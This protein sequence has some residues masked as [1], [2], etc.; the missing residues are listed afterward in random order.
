MSGYTC[1]DSGY[2]LSIFIST[3]SQDY[4]CGICFEILRNPMQCQAGHNYCR[5]CFQSHLNNHQDCPQCRVKVNSLAANL[6][7]KNMIGSMKIRCLL[8][9]ESK[10]CKWTGTVDDL[11]SHLSTNCDWMDVNCPNYR[12]NKKI[13][14]KDIKMHTELLCVI[15]CEYCHQQFPYNSLST[16]L[17]LIC[18][19]N[20]F[21]CKNGCNMMI[22]KR[23]LIVHAQECELEP[24]SCPYYESQCC[25]LN[26]CNGCVARRDYVNHLSDPLNIIPSV[27]SMSAKIKEL[28]ASNQILKNELK[29][30]SESSSSKIKG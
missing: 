22:C 20:P 26:G 30:Q 25:G 13:A 19:R 17:E 8:T 14:R 4:V 21:P 23:D 6:F 7:L 11:E 3:P 24:L 2:P 27:T 28:T 5:E 15:D 18:E 29:I 9:N 16:H 1:L 12:C 10:P